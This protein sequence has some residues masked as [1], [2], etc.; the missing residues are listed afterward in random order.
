MTK[1]YATSVYSQKSTVSAKSGRSYLSLTSGGG[2]TIW[3]LF[4][5]EKETETKSTIWQNFKS[6]IPTATPI[7]TKK[8]KKMDSF[9]TLTI[10]SSNSSITSSTSSK[11]KWNKFLMSPTQYLTRNRDNNKTSPVSS[12]NEIE[13]NNHTLTTETISFID[14]NNNNPPSLYEQSIIYPNN[15]KKN[16]N[17]ILVNHGGESEQELAEQKRRRKERRLYLMRVQHRDGINNRHSF[18]SIGSLDYNNNNN[19]N[20]KRQVGFSDLEGSSSSTLLSTPPDDSHLKLSNKDDADDNNNDK[21]D[22]DIN[23]NFMDESWYAAPKV[24]FVEPSPVPRFRNEPPAPPPSPPYLN[25]IVQPFDST[26]ANK[27]SVQSL[28]INDDNKNNT[29]NIPTIYTTL[30]LTTSPDSLYRQQQSILPSLPLHKS[31]LTFHS[32][33]QRGQTITFSLENAIPEDHIII[34]KFLTS[35][36]VLIPKRRKSSSSSNH[37]LFNIN[38]SSSYIPTASTTSTE[39]YFVRP[40]AGKINR[41]QSHSDIL[42]FLNQVPPLNPGELLK[43]KIL[44]RWAVIQRGTQ[45][46]AWVNQL[47]ESTRRKW[48]EMLLERWPDQVVE[49]KTRISIRFV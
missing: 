25:V 39:R 13:T 23:N 9:D 1:Q 10:K 48:L 42:L 3:P 11:I 44:V 28:I 43:D 16:L 27:K 37:H 20:N 22:K 7:T 19:N 36:S 40:S 17:G 4:K 21:L 2:A 5:K 38:P 18:S 12:L 29:D 24:M 8:K 49:R 33:L 26:N 31:R 46:E 45:V 15:N 14:N 34:F 32:P 41:G 47:K 35:N 30:P 6:L